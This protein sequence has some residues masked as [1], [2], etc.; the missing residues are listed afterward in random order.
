MGIVTAPLLQETTRTYTCYRGTSQ[1]KNK[2]KSRAQH[3]NGGVSAEGFSCV[4]AHF[5]EEVCF[6][7]G[8]SA[9]LR[10]WQ[11]N[12][13]VSGLRPHADSS[14]CDRCLPPAFGQGGEKTNLNHG[15]K[16]MCPAKLVSMARD[17]DAMEIVPTE[18]NNDILQRLLVG[19]R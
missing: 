13:S 6:C 11:G 9:S 2:S 19:L 12:L 17:A 14:L 8:P 5:L 18:P 7:Q 1:L 10:I 4:T 16:S 15:M 3:R